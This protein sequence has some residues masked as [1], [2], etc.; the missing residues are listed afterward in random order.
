MNDTEQ[1]QIEYAIRGRALKTA[2]RK[3]AFV[4]A[5]TLSTS[6]FLLLLMA[7]FIY[8]I[9][10]RPLPADDLA[11]TRAPW[12]SPESMELNS[13]IMRVMSLNLNYA[14]GLEDLDVEHGRYRQLSRDAVQAVLDEAVRTIAESKADV[15]LLQAVDFGSRFAGEMDQAEYLASKLGFGFVVRSMVWRHSYLPFPAPL[16]GEMLGP[17]EAGL[18]V[19]SRL[20]VVKAKR[21]SLPPETLADWWAST[22]APNYCVMEV[23]VSAAGKRILLFN[24]ALTRGD[25]MVRERQAR[26][27]ARVVMQE[28]ARNSLLGGTFFAPPKDPK[29]MGRERLDYTMDLVRHSLNFRTLVTDREMLETPERHVTFT[30]ADGPPVIADYLL[31]EKG[32]RA[33]TPTVVEPA[34]AFS[35]HR[36]LL[37]EIVP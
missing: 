2:L 32:I 8:Q 17:V 11:I 4:L 14:A 28:S 3:T 27:V 20:P 33:K 26:E 29:K 5:V 19:V 9:G 36:P 16:R 30:P 35:T 23:E 18:A 10:F 21:F 13:R 25:V 15:V 6:V 22:F 24:T 31:A 7:L 12:A 34:A 1:P 37:L